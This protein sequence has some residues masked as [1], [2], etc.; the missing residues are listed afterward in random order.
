MRPSIVLVD[1]DPIIRMDIR[2]MLEDQGYSVVGEA[3]NGEEAIELTIRLKPD[4][5]IMDV[6]MPV[7]NGVKAARIIRKLDDAAAVLLLTAY[8]QKDYVRDACKAGVTAYLVKP[9]AEE[10]LIPAVEIALSQKERL[11]SLRD[12]LNQMKQSVEHRKAVEKAKGIVMQAYALNEEEAYRK[13]RGASMESRISLNK[14]AEHI[15]EGRADRLSGMAG[16]G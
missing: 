16:N 14:L 9:V 13:M 8:S 3:K 2:E 15:L 7:M 6:K 1:D 4:L 12:E 11:D 10:N 5:V